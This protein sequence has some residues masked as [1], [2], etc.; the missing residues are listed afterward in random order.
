VIGR[1]GRFRALVL[2]RESAAHRHGQGQGPGRRRQP[3]EG[4]CDRAAQ[5]HGTDQ[6]LIQLTLSRKGQKIYEAI[7]P[8]ARAIEAEVTEG[9]SPRPDI[10]GLHKVLDRYRCALDEMESD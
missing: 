3:S 7:I 6:R 8:R 4:R 5:V 2:Q 1:A 10:A 9:G